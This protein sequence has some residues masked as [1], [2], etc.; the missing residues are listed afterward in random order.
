MRPGYISPAGETVNLPGNLT[1]AT[2]MRIN[3]Y[4]WLL[5]VEEV[6]VKNPGAGY[7]HHAQCRAHDPVSMWLRRQHVSLD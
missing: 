6:H 7:D 4:R 2:A 3:P 5:K 1:S